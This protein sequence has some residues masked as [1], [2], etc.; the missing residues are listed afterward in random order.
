VGSEKSAKGRGQRAKGK[1]K[2]ASS[3]MLQAIAAA[4]NKELNN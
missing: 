3:Y 1:E 2:T 4:S